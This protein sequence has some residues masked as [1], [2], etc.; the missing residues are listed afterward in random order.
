[1]R[2]TYKSLKEISEEL[3]EELGYEIISFEM[4][5]CV[6]HSDIPITPKCKYNKTNYYKIKDQRLIK[7]IYKEKK[8][9]LNVRELAS[10]CKTKQAQILDIIKMER[11]Q[12]TRVAPEKV[13]SWFFFKKHFKSYFD[14]TSLDRK[15]VLVPTRV[16]GVDYTECSAPLCM[17][18]SN[19]NRWVIL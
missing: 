5:D 11:V 12:S 18:G 3:S 7:K 16:E 8:I 19:R 2:S 9:L 1:M 6:I 15:K 14:T 17:W 13:Y 4:R 10:K